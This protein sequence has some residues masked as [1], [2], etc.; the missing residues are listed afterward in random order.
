MNKVVK[1][2]NLDFS[3]QHHNTSTQVLHKINLEIE[4]GETFGLVGESGCGKSTLAYLCL[5]YQDPLSIIHNGKVEING[6]NITNILDKEKNKF[7]GKI[8]SLV[9]QNPT[10][11]L[12]P[13]MQV[14]IQISEILIQHN[15]I[16]NYQSGKN[17]I[18]KLFKSVGLIVLPLAV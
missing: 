9:P 8:I 7:R 3:Y 10:T 5:G 13:H 15:Q 12:S 18:K 11:S 14:G 17:Q 16:E 6:T 2:S 4:E 1:I